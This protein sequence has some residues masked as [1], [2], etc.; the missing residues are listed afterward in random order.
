MSRGERETREERRVHAARRSVRARAS[1]ADASRGASKTEKGECGARERQERK[2]ERESMNGS[3]SEIVV[4]D[5]RIFTV[6]GAE[7]PCPMA[8][9]TR[10]AIRLFKV[11]S[12][13]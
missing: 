8:E 4:R 12:P 6:A 11:F 13:D 1:D 3:L 2:R 5:E 9:V 7:S 10:R